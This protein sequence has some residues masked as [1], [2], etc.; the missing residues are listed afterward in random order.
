M[1]K[2]NFYRINNCGDECPLNTKTLDTDVIHYNN[3]IH[4]NIHNMYGHLEAIMTRKAL[5][6]IKPNERPFVLSRSTFAGSGR[7]AGHWTGDNWS[8]WRHLY[9]SIPAVL[10]FQLFGIPFV[11]ADICGF[12]GDTTEELCSRWMQL[13]A[14]YPFSR[15]HNAKGSVSQEPYLWENVLESAKIALGIRYSLIPFYY[16][17]FYENSKYGHPVIRALFFEFPNDSATLLL[18]RQFLVGPSIMIVPVLERGKIT[19]SG[20]LPSG[21]WYNFYSH[22]LLKSLGKWINIK[23]DITHIPVFVRGGY[24]IPMQKPSLTLKEQMKNEY[25]LLVALDD[26]GMAR[27]NLYVDD[28]ISINTG[29]NYSLIQFMVQ[30]SSFHAFGYFGY[31]KTPILGKIRILGLSKCPKSLVFND[32]ENL[33]WKCN[34]NCL[35]I[36]LKL[37]L[38]KSFMIL[39]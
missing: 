6:S 11:G 17:L 21:I 39:L 14:F 19:V 38:K 4:E 25:E 12:L 27:G 7:Y 13:G 33:E 10:N 34:D 24:I 37:M 28:G 36:T 1:K 20:Y 8:T 35:E 3:T 31:K 23:A 16:T 15:N 26:N 30:N 29:E 9:L 5:L 32:I 2:N 18:D 22:E